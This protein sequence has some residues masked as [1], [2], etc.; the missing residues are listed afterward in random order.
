MLANFDKKT[1]LITEGT[2]SMGLNTAL[3]FARLG[4][5]YI[6]TYRWGAS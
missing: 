1:V 2:R 4:A 6:I 3:L 5:Q